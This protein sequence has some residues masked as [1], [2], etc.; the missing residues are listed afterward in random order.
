MQSGSE[1]KNKRPPAASDLGYSSP[2]LESVAPL[3]G[4]CDR[5]FFNFCLNMTQIK[6]RYTALISYD[7]DGNVL[8]IY[9]E[10]D[11]MISIAAMKSIAEYAKAYVRKYKTQ[12]N[13][14]LIDYKNREAAEIAEIRRKQEERE[15]KRIQRTGPGPDFHCDIYLLKDTIRDVYKVGRSSNFHER[16]KQLKTANAGIELVACYKGVPNDEKVIHSVYDGFEKRVSGEWFKLNEADIDYFVKYF[17]KC[18][19]PF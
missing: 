16:F 18:D 2:I 15:K 5:R 12:D 9:N 11:T 19:L 1:E 8:A 3:P 10:F 7:E 14:D 17:V 6:H 13:L 4:R